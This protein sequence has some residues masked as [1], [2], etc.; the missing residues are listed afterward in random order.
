MRRLFGGGA[1]RDGDGGGEGGWK[2]AFLLEAMPSP[3]GT[4]RLRTAP[5]S[6]PGHGLQ[7]LSA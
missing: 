1:G 4:A 3:W 5:D 7:K 2:V 6:K